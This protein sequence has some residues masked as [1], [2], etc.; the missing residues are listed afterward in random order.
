ME[1]EDEE[2][3]RKRPL[4]QPRGR[5]EVVDEQ[6]PDDEHGREFEAEFGERGEQAELVKINTGA[7]KM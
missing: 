4:R 6:K 7:D 2:W 5:S 1:K 3:E